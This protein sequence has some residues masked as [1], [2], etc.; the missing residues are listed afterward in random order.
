MLLGYFYASGGRVTSSALAVDANMKVADLIDTSLGCWKEQ[1]IDECLVSFDAQRIKAIPLCDIPQPDFL[2]WALERNGIYS[3]KSG[4]RASCE[5]ARSGEASGSN[6]ET[7]LDCTG[8]TP[9]VNTLAGSTKVVRRRKWQPPNPGEYKTNFDGAMFNECD[10]AGVGIV[11]RDSGGNRVTTVPLQRRLGNG[12]Q[13]VGMP[14]S[15]LGHMFRDTLF[16]VTFMRSFSFA[17]VLRQKSVPS[18]I[19][20][21][22]WA[23]FQAAK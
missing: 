22:V 4:Y 23:D 13:G 18:D 12:Y 11:I 15:S 16:H 21:F 14:F 3:V 1:K 20:A 10:E 9:A 7:S 2:Y 8:S 6:S 19:D 17:H 5:E